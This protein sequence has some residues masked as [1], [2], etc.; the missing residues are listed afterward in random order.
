MSCTSGLLM[1]SLT[2]GLVM[3]DIWF[4]RSERIPLHLFF[5]AIVTVLFYILCQRGYE[6]VN[7]SMIGIVIL[8]LV[9]SMIPRLH[10]SS[11]QT[12]SKTSC[13]TPEVSCSRCE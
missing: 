5:G 1:G 13:S 7:W 4:W 12:S 11:Y 10:E 6:L 3:A 8:S 9:L 2:V